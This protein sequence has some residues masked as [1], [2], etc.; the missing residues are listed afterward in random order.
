MKRMLRNIQK[1][2]DKITENHTSAYAA[3]SAFFIVLSLIPIILLLLTL[4]QFTPVTKGDVMTAVVQ[5]IPKSIYPTII[6][7]VNQV[8]NQSRT[9]IPLTAVVAVWSA[10]RGVLSM[11]SGLNCVYGSKETRNYV[12]L[13]I[14]AGFY[15]LLFLAAIVLSLIILVFGNSLSIFINSYFPVVK[16]IMDYLIATR[17]IFAIVILTMINMTIYRFL[18]NKKVLFRRQLPGAI[19]TAIGWVFASFLF[20]AYLD[21]FKGFSDMYGSLTTIVLIMLWLYFCMYVM[22]LGGEIN[23]I[24]QMVIKEEKSLEL[25]DKNR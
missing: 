23:V 5:V 7:I 3:Q 24:Y 14:R 21:I 9:V 4:V 17:T 10:G 16:H 25:L 22:L 11:S 13:R 1:F 6:S 20:S 8:Y 12:Y 2:T 18:P 15:T 19:F